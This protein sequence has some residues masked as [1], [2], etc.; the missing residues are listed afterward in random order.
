MIAAS[1]QSCV[2]KHKI[3]SDIR[4]E[5][6]NS[7]QPFKRHHLTAKKDLPNI[8]TAFG[9]SNVQR[10]PN[11]QCSVKAQV[12]EWSSSESNPILF[13]KFQGVEAPEGYSLTKDDF[14]IVIQ[15]P[16]QKIMAQ[17]F[18]HKGICVDSTHG[19][20]GY[21]FLLTSVVV[22]DEFVEGVPIGWLLSNHEYFTH[23]CIF[24]Y[25]AEEKLWCICVCMDNQQDFSA[26]GMQT[27]HGR[28]SFEPKLKTK[29]LQQK[30]TRCSGWFCSKQ[31]SIVFASTCHLTDRLP[32]LNKEFKIFPAR[33]GR[34]TRAMGLLL[35]DW[36]GLDWR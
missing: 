7:N 2:T 4:G 32:E 25:N 6:V 28:K 1:L 20:T 19:T 22:L 36:I 12:Q 17:K 15:T 13:T 27:E 9:I 34:K 16:F 3:L 30:S 23:M 8:E 31:M 29:Q 10:H 24:F 33:M 14:L 18:A 35:Q 21:D 11:D 26:H 5:A